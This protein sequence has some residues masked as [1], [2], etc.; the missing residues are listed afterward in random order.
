MTPDPYE[1]TTGDLIDLVYDLQGT[2]RMLAELLAQDRNNPISSRTWDYL[3]IGRSHLQH[4]LS[5]QLH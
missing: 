1:S 2:L 4:D 5:R 3:A